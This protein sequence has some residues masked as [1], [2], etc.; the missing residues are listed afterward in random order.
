MC[1]PGQFR[2]RGWACGLQPALHHNS[3]VESAHPGLLGKV[4]LF[5]CNAS[6]KTMVMQ[7][8]FWGSEL[9]RTINQFKN[10][11]KSRCQFPKLWYYWHCC[12][13]MSSLP[14]LRLSLG[15]YSPLLTSH[16]VTVLLLAYF[17]PIAQGL[18][19]YLLARISM[20]PFTKPRIKNLRDSLK[21][22]SQIPDVVFHW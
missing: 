1:L 6:I 8:H 17:S 19:R 20:L 3:R 2:G 22:T 4:P 11:W 12:W 10:V 5:L 18:L 7:S 14:G 13:C 15:N 21:T 9:S 16:K